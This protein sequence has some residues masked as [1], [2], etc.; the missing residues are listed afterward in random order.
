M[1]TNAEQFRKVAELCKRVIG[2][3]RENA[4]DFPSP[5]PAAD[6]L[7]IEHDKLRELIGLAVGDRI[8]KEERNQQAEVV[9]GM[10]KQELRYVNRVARG[11]KVLVL[12]SGFDAGKEWQRHGNPKAPVIAKIEDG[13]EPC[14]ARITL[15]GPLI[16]RGL[17]TVQVCNLAEGIITGE[18]S[19]HS[20]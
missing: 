2:A 14:S 8:K 19:I 17:Y 16:R 5:E 18:H 4:T 1:N 11:D 10:L 15:A 20:L 9:F 7:E 6:D 13:P 12:K 3:L